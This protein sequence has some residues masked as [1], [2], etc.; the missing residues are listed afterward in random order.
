MEVFN[1]ICSHYKSSNSLPPLRIYITGG[2]GTRKTFL[3]TTI[4]EW[5]RLCTSQHAGVDPII[6]TAPTGTAT[7]NIRGLTLHSA[8][9]LPVQ[10]GREPAFTKLSSKSLRR[11]RQ[12]FGHCHTLLIEEISMVSSRLLLYIDRRLREIQDNNK[13]YRNMNIITVGNF[14][15][16][17]D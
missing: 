12:L 13:P 1:H 3:T 16:F 5:L 15:N 10:H 6:L 14:G 9:H 4:I 11:L 7:R 2:A 8:L 17:A